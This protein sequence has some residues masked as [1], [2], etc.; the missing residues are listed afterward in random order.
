MKIL[1]SLLF[2]TAI[3]TCYSQSYLYLQKNNEVPYKRL[4]LYDTVIF[5]TDSS[6][7]V[8]GKIHSISNEVIRID[9]VD[10]L[11]ADIVGFR[12][13]NEL[14]YLGGTAMAI[15]GVGFT[16]IALVNRTVNGDTPLLRPGQIV[17]G[18]A[19][20]GAGLLVRWLSR[21]TYLRDKGWHWKVISLDNLD[22][23]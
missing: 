17:F 5:K 15:A 10:Y 23:K 21:K 13:H 14:I 19:L 22:E 11:L 3:L 18:A 8:G 16:G 20:S 2:C 7:W 4:G 12:T 9:G 6:E 1:L